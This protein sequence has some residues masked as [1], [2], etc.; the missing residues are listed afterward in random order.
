MASSYFLGSSFNLLFLSL[1]FLLFHPSERETSE[2]DGRL[3]PLISR[4]RYNKMFSA[5]MSRTPLDED[6]GV[7]SN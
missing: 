1:L 6:T 5:T 4:I 7:P 2:N 3:S